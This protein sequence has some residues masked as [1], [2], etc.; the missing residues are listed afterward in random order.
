MKNLKILSIEDDSHLQDVI[1]AYFEAEDYTVFLVSTLDAAFEIINQHDLDTILLDLSL[2]DVKTLS[3]IPKICEM[4]A[5]SVIVVSGK[6]DYM[7]K[8]ICLE[9]GAD[10]YVTKP[11]ELR[12]L[13]ARIKAILRRLKENAVLKTDAAKDFSQKENIAFDGWLLDRQQYQLFDNNKKSV[14]LTTG[15]FKLLEA[16]VL[17]NKRTLTRNQLFDITRDQSYDTYDRAIDVQIARIRKKI[18][19]HAGLLKTVRGVGY[20]FVSETTTA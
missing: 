7:E 11:F 10:D 12:E 3:A 16:L 8:I 14:D 9:M 15:E 18:T 19:V 6:D 13:A 17:A 4:S 1:A 20:M 5:A 2:G